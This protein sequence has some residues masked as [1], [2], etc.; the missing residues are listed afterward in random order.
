H[1]RVIE[2]V[3]KQIGHALMRC[4]TIGQAPV[5][6][7]GALR[8]A[9]D[10][11]RML[12]RRKESVPPAVLVFISVSNLA[13]ITRFHGRDVSNTL[14]RHVLACAQNQPG[15]DRLFRNG[16]EIIALVEHSDLFEATAAGRNICAMSMG[17]LSAGTSGN[18]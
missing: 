14:L 9:D 11:D 6:P 1:R 12:S 17:D 15:L 3:A 5:D 4:S 8:D 13:E 18:V 2:A 16:D 10:L 7:L